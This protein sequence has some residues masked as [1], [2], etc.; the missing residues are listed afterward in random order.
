MDA[1][2]K[3]GLQPGSETVSG[4]VETERQRWEGEKRGGRQREH[5]L[6]AIADSEMRSSVFDRFEPHMRHKGTATQTSLENESLYSEG[7]RQ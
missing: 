4:T 1:G 5:N 7:K 3:E 6:R 2:Q